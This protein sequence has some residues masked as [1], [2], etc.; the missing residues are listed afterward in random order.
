MNLGKNI[1]ILRKMT[2]MTQEELAEKM[3]VSRQTISKWELGSILPEIEKLLDLC[4]MFNCSVDQLLKGNMD[5]SNE[6]YSDIR[7][8][9][10]APFRYISYA[11]I[12]REPEEDAI[13]HVENWARQLQVKNPYIIGWDFPPVSQEQR[14]VFHMRGYEAALILEDE[15]DTGDLDAEI[16]SQGQQNYITITL[17]E[18]QDAGEFEIIPNA[19]KALLTYMAI[20]GIKEKHDPEILSCYEHEYFDDKGVKFMDIY[21]AIA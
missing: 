6:A 4:E 18:V 12:S 21:I 5:F 11:A 2:N 8:V 14:N 10:V 13:T 17:E 16:L 19:Y 1:Q 9:T 7:I 3:N 20:N 15:Q